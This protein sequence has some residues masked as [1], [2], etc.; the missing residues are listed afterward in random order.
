MNYLEY[1]D[2]FSLTSNGFFIIN[3]Q[4]EKGISNYLVY[5]EGY[6]SMIWG[7]GDNQYLLDVSI[8]KK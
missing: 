6:N 8:I 3:K 1:I 5:I 7:G 2:L 4:N